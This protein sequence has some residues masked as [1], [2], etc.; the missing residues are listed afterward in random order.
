VESVVNKNHADMGSAAQAG[1]VHA[2]NSKKLKK[3]EL[4]ELADYLYSRYEFKK[5]VLN[6]PKG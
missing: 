2:H 6:K 3:L 1:T 5:K 4:L